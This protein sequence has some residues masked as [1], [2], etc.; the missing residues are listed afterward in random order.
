MARLSAGFAGGE[1]KY[2]VFRE[3]TDIKNIKT[4]AFFFAL[5]YT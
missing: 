1:R 4:I 3:K 5:V 2:S